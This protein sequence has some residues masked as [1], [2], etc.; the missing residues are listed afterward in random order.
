MIAEMAYDLMDERESEEDKKKR[1][2]NLLKGKLSTM[3]KDAVSPAP[4]LDEGAAALLNTITNAIASGEE[5]PLELFANDEKNLVQQLGTL[6][7]GPDKVLKMSELILMATNGTYTD[8][9][10][11]S[12]F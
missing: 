12:C 8:Y 7:I 6:G 10:N 4:P 2:D 9:N 1:L 3:V 11:S 5:N